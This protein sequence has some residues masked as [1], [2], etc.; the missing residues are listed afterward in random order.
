MYEPVYLL[1]KIMEYWIME[2]IPL[3]L[4]LT[5]EFVQL[6]RCDATSIV[7]IDLQVMKMDQTFSLKQISYIILSVI[8]E[9]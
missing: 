5:C 4:P 9:Y 6:T 2:G 7:V 3:S 8:H 1:P